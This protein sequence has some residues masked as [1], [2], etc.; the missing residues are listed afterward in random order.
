MTYD[1]TIIPISKKKEFSTES[2]TNC[3]KSVEK[4]YKTIN[5]GYFKFNPER[6][7]TFHRG[8]D[9][10]TIKKYI[11]SKNSCVYLTDSNWDYM[12]LMAQSAKELKINKNV[13]E[14]VNTFCSDNNINKDVFGIHIRT[15]EFYDNEQQIQNAINSVYGLIQ[16]KISDNSN[17]K[18]FVCSD[19]EDVE[20][21]LRKQLPDN[22]ITLE[23]Y[24]YTYKSVEGTWRESVADVDGRVFPY[25]VN[26][27]PETVIEGFLDMLILSR[28]NILTDS[29]SSFLFFA[30]IYSKLDKLG[31]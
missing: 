20:N 4:V 6:E 17:V 3:G 19:N 23:K 22:I 16:G 10:D 8:M 25:N 1:N 18:I 2:N 28:T 13:L 5:K 31:E 11:K 29:L 26:R 7:V 12:D 21:D 30:K 14:K 27:N 15:G 24:H 9:H